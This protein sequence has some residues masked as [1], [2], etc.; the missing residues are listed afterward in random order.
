[1][2][3]YKLKFVSYVL[4]L[5]SAMFLVNPVQSQDWLEMMDKN[6]ANVYEIKNSF[7]LWWGDR[8]VERGTGWKQFHR[9][10]AEWEPRTYPSG[11]LPNPGIIYDAV[12]QHNNNVRDGQDA[13]S[14][15][16]P[17][18]PYSWTSTSYNPGMGR[19]NCITVDPGNSDIIYVGTPAGGMWKTTNGGTNWF[20]M[21]DH[22]ATLGV[23][24]IAI[25]PSNTS[26]IY[27][28]TGDGDGTQTYSIGILKSTDGGNTFSATGLVWGIADFRRVSRIL[29]NPTTPSTLVAATSNGIYRTTNSGVNWTQ[30]ETGAFY[31]IEFKPGDP[32]VVYA[33]KNRT[34]DARFYKS[35]NG[36]ESFTE[37]TSGLPT[38]STASRY[39]IAVSPDD[40]S[41]VYILAG[42]STNY[43]FLGI[44]RSTNSGTSFTTRSTSPNIM[45]YEMDG[46]SAGGQAWYDIA[47]AVDPT[48]AEVIY[49]GGINIWKSTNGGTSLT[50]NTH[51]IWPPTTAGYSHADIHSLDFYGTTLYCGS[52]GGIYTTPDAGTTWSNK[53]FGLQITQFYKIAGTPSG[54]YLL[55]GGTQ[56]NGS[57]RFRSGSFT[58]VFGADGA[59]CAINYVD[60]NIVF[61]S[62]QNGGILRSTNSGATFVDAV[63][64]IT[65]SG[66]FI[67]PFEMS[68]AVPTTLYAGFDN[69]WKTTNSAASWTKISTFG[70]SGKINAISISESSPATIYCAKGSTV[71]KTTNDGGNW[72]SVSTGLPSLSVTGIDI[73]NTDPSKVWITFSGYTAGS[74]VYKTTNGGTSWENY[75]GSLPN[76]PA[77]CIKFRNSS[78]DGVYVGTDVGV[79]YRNSTHGDWLP[80]STG[81]PNVVIKDL[82]IHYGVQKLRAGTF[83]RGLWESALDST[84]G[85]DPISS[86]IPDRFQLHQNYPN[87]FNPST[88][89]RY[90]VVNKSHVTLMIYDMSGRLVRTLLNQVLATGERLIVWDGR[91]NNGSP[92][93][94]GIYIY[95]LTAGNLKQSKKMA[96]VK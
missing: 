31:D 48:D 68:P 39:S 77:N 47:L 58:H 16:T 46:S 61:V 37:I 3:S 33:A 45:G 36:G 66:A 81:L 60:T 90:D 84:V 49:T 59:D 86:N 12:L 88:T 76:I 89:I 15:W 20:T 85:V 21:T 6:D 65:E 78:S 13:G 62:Y 11:D 4:I 57:N 27:I 38:P 64:G 50:I 72:T 74:K 52:D 8:K 5:L 24:S 83:G 19:V 41:Y 14:N 28:G 70:V 67:T 35:T 96:L 75:S 54:P 69:I 94:S 18:G 7:D 55:Y 82:E 56:D 30:V 17:M 87:P 1:M 2:K 79:Y 22:L 34:S 42:N 44:Y 25:D 40:P 93:S 51:W 53:S 43:G 63:S 9:W 73:S 95:E 29:I 23:S 80:F 10:Y 71:F 91:D 26:T 92:V 32:S